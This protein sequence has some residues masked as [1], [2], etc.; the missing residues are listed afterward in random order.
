MRLTVRVSPRGGRDA[1]E[2]WG[3]DP[4]GR[5]FLKLRVA[6][7][8]VDGVAN[9]SVEALVARALGL[10]RSSVRV[11]RG[12]TARLKQLEIEG[13]TVQAIWAAFG[14]PPEG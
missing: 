14:A 5:P 2:G 9:A 12:Q 8:P 13:L 6:A 4:D 3:A 7:A 1:V 10:P 11:A